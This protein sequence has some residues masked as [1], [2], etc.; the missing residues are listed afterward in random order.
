M[1]KK[2][3]GLLVLLAL[4]TNNIEAGRKG[5][6]SKA[7]KTRKTKS[8]KHNKANRTFGKKGYYV[9][10]ARE[11]GSSYFEKVKNKKAADKMVRTVPGAVRSYNQEQYASYL[12]T[13]ASQHKKKNKDKK[14]KFEIL[15]TAAAEAGIT[16]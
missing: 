16:S 5:K 11:D 9:R 2:Y 7:T 1:N 13:I 15:D 12:S 8:P 14:N 4:C 10:I 3:F 6:H